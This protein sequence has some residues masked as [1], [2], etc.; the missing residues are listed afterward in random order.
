MAQSRRITSRQAQAIKTRNKILKTTI[1]MMQKKGFDNITI[2]AI[3]KKAGVSVGSFYYYFKS[4]NDILLDIFHKADDYLH[5]HIVE[6]GTLKSAEEQIVNFYTHYA[7]YAK[8]TSIDFT[9]RL[10]NTDNKAF[11]NRDRVMYQILL[12]IIEKGQA[13]GEIVRT[14]DAQEIVD[15]LFITARGIVF[16][17]CLH[18]GNYDIEVTMRNYM[19]RLV[20]VFR[21]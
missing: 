17:W 5:E 8:L 6:N 19:Q 18:D 10:Y 9:K 20:T 4:K 13:R 7:R 14:T 2:E 15:Y 12:G 21:P 16:D 3:S 1:E 11:L